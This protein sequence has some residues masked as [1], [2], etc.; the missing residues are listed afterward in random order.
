MKF[1]VIVPVYNV[2]RYL[3]KCLDSI[4]TQSYDDYEIIVV[5]DGSPDNSQAIIDEYAAKYP[6]KIKAFKKENGGLSDARNFGIQKAQGDYLLFIDSDDY[7]AENLLKELDAVISKEG[8][9]MVRFSGQVIYED[10]REGE[11]IFCPAF[12]VY[13]GEKAL[14]R[15]IDNKQYF[16]PAWLYAYRRDF[17]QKNCFA[18]STGRYHE[19]FGLTPEVILKAEKFVATEYVGYNYVQSDFSIIRNADYDKTIAKANDILYHTLRLRGIAEALS[20]SE[21]T[22]KKFES[23]LANAAINQIKLLKSADRKRYISR[24]KSEKIF[25]MLLEDNIKRKLKKIYLK[26]R[27]GAF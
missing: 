5:N 19:D 1:S 15:L 6:E 2:E 22:R 10:G 25:D 14:D 11:R 7:V 27:Y 13:S 3:A 26:I 4:L 23:I 17:W 21:L 20:L 16:E 9:D 18:F 24:L 8:P 12:S